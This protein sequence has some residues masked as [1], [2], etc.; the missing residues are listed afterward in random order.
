MA[1]CFQLVSLGA[2]LVGPNGVVFQKELRGLPSNPTPY[3]TSALH[4]DQPL[5][6]LVVAH[7]TCPVISSVPHFCTVSIFPCLVF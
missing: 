4:E 3:I 7:F 5:V 2:V 1:C 6:W